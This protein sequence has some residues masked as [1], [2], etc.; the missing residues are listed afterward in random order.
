M[1]DEIERRA[2]YARNTLLAILLVEEAKH[3]N[4]GQLG[5]RAS[6]DERVDAVDP[7]MLVDHPPKRKTVESLGV[8]ENSTG[9]PALVCEERAS[10][11]SL[12]M[13][14]ALAVA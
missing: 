6:S 7:N 10:A 12:S 14:K 2:S 11:S 9:V 5:K 4:E 3:R 8:T 13:V 1:H